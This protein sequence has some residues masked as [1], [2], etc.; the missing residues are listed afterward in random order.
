VT[1][2]L[3]SLS[4]LFQEAPRYINAQI[5]WWRLVLS[6]SARAFV[7]TAVSALT[8]LASVAPHTMES[9]VKAEVRFWSIINLLYR[10]S[11]LQRHLL[12]LSY[13]F[14]DS[15]H[16]RYCNVHKKDPRRQ[17]EAAGCWARGRV[18]ERKGDNHSSDSWHS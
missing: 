6:R 16:R 13:P 15:A 1:S 7:K 11:F 5:S 3:F 2:A 4:G 9:S 10:L 14:P 18:G 8:V 12:H 17:I